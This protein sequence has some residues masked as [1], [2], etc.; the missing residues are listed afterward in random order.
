MQSQV[1]TRDQ[2]EMASKLTV[3]D[4]VVF[5]KSDDE[6]EPIW[7]GRIMSNPEWQE[8]GTYTN[9]SRQNPSFRGDKVGRGEVDLYVM[10]Y[11]KINVMSDKLEY[12]VSRSETE[13][14]VQNNRYL[15]PV[16]VKLH[17]MLRQPNV[18]PKLR[19]STR[20]DIEQSEINNQR[21]IK[22]W[23]NKELE[24]VWNMDSELRRLALSSCDL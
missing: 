22:D 3:G 9:N 11:E 17:Q 14:T 13:P 1:L 15:I 8:Q 19:T 12:W 23:H 4:F 10:W 18:V 24:I 2:N 20:G 6:V 16:E 21:R 7:L 5:D